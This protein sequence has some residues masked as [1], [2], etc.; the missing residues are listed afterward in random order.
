MSE[1]IVYLF[2][3]PRYT[4]HEI[5]WGAG[6]SRLLEALLHEVLDATPSG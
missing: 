6:D 5:K 4:G 1:R 3:D 2:H